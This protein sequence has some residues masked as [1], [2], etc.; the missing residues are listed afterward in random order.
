MNAQTSGSPEPSRA[1]MP[2]CEAEQPAPYAGAPPAAAPVALSEPPA[3]PSFS[4][5]AGAAVDAELSAPASESAASAPV[6]GC[7]PLPLG[8]SESM[9]SM[10]M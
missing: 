4:S 3:F 2:A 5:A 6:V 8:R 1:G 10:E 7:G 9:P